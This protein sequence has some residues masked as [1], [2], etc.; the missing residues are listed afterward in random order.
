M[1]QLPDLLIPGNTLLVLG[2]TT[3]VGAIGVIICAYRRKSCLPPSPPTWRL[4]GHFL[5]PQNASFTIARWID[6]YGP[7]ITI[8]SGIQ[9]I[10]IIGRYK[11]AMDIM[12]K[13]GRILADRPRLVA[14]EIL[15]YGLD[16]LL[17]HTGD[18]LRRMRRAL[19]THLQPKSAEAY[20]PLQ[21]S[22]AKNVIL[23]ILNDPHNFQH[24]VSSCAATT[25]MK[26]TYGK[27]TPM[28]ETDPEIKEF[29]HIARIY[30]PILRHRYYLLDSIP[31]LKYLPWYAPE[32]RDGFRRTMRLFTGKLNRVRQQIQSNEDI[33]PSFSKYILENGHLYG[34]TENEMAYLAGVLFG[35]GS[36][37]TATAIC[38]V[39]MAAARF[40]EEQARVQAEIDAIIGRERAPTFADKPSLPRLEAFISEALRWRP[41]AAEGVPHR[42]TEDENYCI[43]AGT[44]VVGNHWAISRDPDIYPEP[45]AFKPQRW[46]DDQ[47]RLRDD[48]TFLVYGFGRRVCP[49]LH[50]ANRSVFINSLLILWAFELSLDHTKP[51]DDMG[52]MNAV[53]PNV[54]CAIE[55]RTRVSEAE[56][57]CMMQNYPED[58]VSASR[59]N[60]AVLL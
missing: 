4:Q 49:G 35:A 19:H 17:T 50:V 16:L 40:P 29:R 52:F 31:W 23:N 58:V 45:E 6:E 59:G 2:A 60:V 18:R 21:M 44:T 8:R 24:H 26:L 54:P 5:P 56:L 46:I 15:T 53:I 34:L 39:L 10:V 42:T 30:R 32:L 57:R 22:Q 20:Q 3:C 41:L 47:G 14:G 1:L 12:E 36:Q 13:Q 51:Q 7:L 37:T 55:F 25:I 11:A 28:S 33:G 9:T 43:P 48:L 27:I 38:T